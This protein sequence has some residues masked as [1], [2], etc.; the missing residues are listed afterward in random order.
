M[1]FVTTS[2]LKDK[3]AKKCLKVHILNGKKLNIF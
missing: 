1:L 2:T 3:K